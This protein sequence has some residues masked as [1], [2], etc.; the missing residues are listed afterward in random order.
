MV[1]QLLACADNAS[2]ILTIAHAINLLLRPSS[3]VTDY[4]TTAQVYGL[5][6]LVKGLASGRQGAR[7]GYA[8]ALTTLMT[9]L[10]TLPAAVVLDMLDEHLEVSGQAKA[11]FLIFHHL[12]LES[13]EPMW[14]N[15]LPISKQ[16]SLGKLLNTLILSAHFWPQTWHMSSQL[17]C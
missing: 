5:K 17:P 7:Q 10:P 9:E 13:L 6:R 14:A 15:R 1:E 8:L 12:H 4:R 16:S 2:T 11:S 3:T